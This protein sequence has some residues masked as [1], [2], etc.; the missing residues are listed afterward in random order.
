MLKHPHRKTNF[1]RTLLQE[2]L[3]LC[4]QTVVIHVAN[5]SAKVPKNT[6]ALFGDFG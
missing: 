3:V 2:V 6:V 5:F 1:K 4:H